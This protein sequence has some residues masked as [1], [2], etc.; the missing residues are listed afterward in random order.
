MS[1]NFFPSWMNKKEEEE[2]VNFAC[3][4]H[5]LPFKNSFPGSSFYFCPR[6]KEGS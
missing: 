6:L 5:N 3:L 1:S 2:E 4:K